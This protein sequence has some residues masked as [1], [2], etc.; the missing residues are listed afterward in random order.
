MMLSLLFEKKNEVAVNIFSREKQE[1]KRSQGLH[2]QSDIVCQR[3]G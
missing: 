3:A 2:C 1:N